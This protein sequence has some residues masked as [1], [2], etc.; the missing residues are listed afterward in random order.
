MA[1]WKAEHEKALDRPDESE[2]PP[3]LS[4]SNGSGD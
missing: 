4:Q 1:K 2:D 3:V